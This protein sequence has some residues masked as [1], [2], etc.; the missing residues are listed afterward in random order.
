MGFDVVS[1]AIVVTVEIQTIGDAIAVSVGMV[2]CADHELRI[3]KCDAA[4]L[5]KLV[6]A[7]LNTRSTVV[8]QID[9]E[10][11]SRAFLQ[12][13]IQFRSAAEVVT[14]VVPINAEVFQQKFALGGKAVGGNFDRQIVVSKVITTTASVLRAVI[15]LRQLHDVVFKFCQSRK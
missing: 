12:L 8:V 10:G 14:V 13:V 15:E 5:V 4:D 11:V 9:T 1:D 7:A 2:R 3:I 6:V